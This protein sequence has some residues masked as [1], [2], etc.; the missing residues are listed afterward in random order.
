MADE[1]RV[2]L[3]QPSTT[4]AQT[5]TLADSLR[6]L[7]QSQGKIS[8]IKDLD[9]RQ[10]ALDL[11]T[12]DPDVREV[13]LKVSPLTKKGGKLT[14]MVRKAPSP[15]QRKVS[16]AR[17][18]KLGTFKTEQEL[19]PLIAAANEQQ[20]NLKAHK[21]AV[22]VNEAA[23]EK[24]GL[25]K[26]ITLENGIKVKREDIS[27]PINRG[28]M[29][30]NYGDDP[31]MRQ[32]LDTVK[33]TVGAAQIKQALQAGDE[34]FLS[35]LILGGELETFRADTSDKVE[36]NLMKQAITSLTGQEKINAGLNIL[37]ANNKEKTCQILDL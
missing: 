10:A 2:T 27:N 34:D 13:F 30:A 9:K 3:E 29:E 6:S 35:N 28:A 16:R 8:A 20:L 23:L 4:I 32:A 19:A 26:V 5:A 15:T 24:L 11:L 37:D 7:I 25:G 17:E 12:V 22:G 31:V 14:E 18:E 36:A 1:T 33:K 21:M